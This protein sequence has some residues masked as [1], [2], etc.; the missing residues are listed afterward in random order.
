MVSCIRNQGPYVRTQQKF[1]EN[2]HGSPSK[3][4]I[5]QLHEEKPVTFILRHYTKLPFA[6]GKL[7]K[8]EHTGTERPDGTS[9]LSGQKGQIETKQQTVKRSHNEPG[10]KVE[11]NTVETSKYIRSNQQEMT[12]KL[13]KEARKHLDVKGIHGESKRDNAESYNCSDDISHNETSLLE[14]T[15]QTKIHE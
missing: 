7:V 3:I 11:I 1:F 5:C 15:H 2:W 6:Q 4:A 10:L 9:I 14:E 12:D 8:G 13:R